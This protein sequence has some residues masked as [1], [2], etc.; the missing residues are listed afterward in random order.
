MIY[1]KR[2]RFK[3]VKIKKMNEF[4]KIL[5]LVLL[6]SGLIMSVFFTFLYQKALVNTSDMISR[7]KHPNY[8]V[9]DL[10]IT[11]IFNE[12]IIALIFT[13]IGSVLLIGVENK[14]V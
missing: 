5:G 10:I 2:R 1:L 12:V 11:P 14:K 8:E 4:K 3:Y 9:I 13:L 6:I 7:M